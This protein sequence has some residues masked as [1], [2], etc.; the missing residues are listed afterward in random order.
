M[1]TGS[2]SPM[3]DAASSK[4]SVLKTQQFNTDTYN[5]VSQLPKHLKMSI[6][7][8]GEILANAPQWCEEIWKTMRKN[9]F[10]TKGSLNLPIIENIYNIHPKKFE[11]MLGVHNGTE[12]FEIMDADQN[13]SINE[14][15]QVL[16][17]SVI[18][19]KMVKV[20][21]DLCN[22]QE[23]IRYR[24]M[25][26]AVR[27][28]EVQI[29]R[30]Q[31]FLRKKIYQSEAAIY[32]QIGEAR[33]EEFYAYYEEEFKQFNTYSLERIS[34]LRDQH[35]EQLNVLIDKLDRAVVALK[36]KPKPTLKE[37]QTQEK[38]VSIDERVEEAMNFRKELKDLEVSE[39]QRI[40]RL[41]IE[42][43]ERQKNT[44]LIEQSKEMKHLESKMSNEENKLIIRMKR[45]F[46]VLMKKTHLHENEI[47][48]IQGLAAK[49]AM[50]KALNDGELKRMKAKS[51]KMNDI[52]VSV[53][54]SSTGGI[55]GMTSNRSPVSLPPFNGSHGTG[56]TKR[57]S[58]FHNSITLN[59]TDMSNKTNTEYAK[60]L[61]KSPNVI[62]F[63]LKKSYGEE[64]PVSAKPVNYANEDKL[65][66]KKVEIYL[67]NKIEKKDEI[68]PLT[69]LYDEFLRPIE[70]SNE[71][72]GSKMTAE[73]KKRTRQF[74]NEKLN[75]D[76][77]I[78]AV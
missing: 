77:K 16:L 38:L 9:D 54:G 2:I 21:D 35:E 7:R 41:R 66:H 49:Y 57:G 40:N 62:S 12:L 47:K 29:S 36:F 65:S 19:E 71:E 75:G 17:F 42:N 70:R 58:H 30:Y 23:Y 45:D 10:A 28:I 18:K 27:K 61:T 63:H 24:D 67:V 69:S 50:Q 3:K 72:K 25:M 51:K 6:I 56:M 13:G 32:H 4:F 11:K 55:M 26:K 8:D 73:E 31:D 20:S 60:Q 5:T 52:L 74:I 76:K 44:L 34:T 33:F 64:P 14:D 39:A 53:N 22:I 15:E 37:Y 46:D 48:K 43:I 59:S 68:P 78:A 1:R